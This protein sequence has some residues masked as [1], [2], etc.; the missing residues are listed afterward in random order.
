[1][2]MYWEGPKYADRHEAGLVL[3]GKLAEYQSKNPILLAI[4]NGGVAVGVPIARKLGC[5]L[6]LIVVRKLV[7]PDQPE[8]GFGSV[9]S[10][11]S[12]LL[13]KPLVR[14]F[15]LGDEM[16]AIQSERA[17]KTIGERL[18]MYGNRAQLPPLK[19]RTVILVD[20]GLASGFTM[21]AAIKVV[22]VHEPCMVIVAVPTS[23]MTAYR[24]LI[25]LVDR[26]VCPDVSGL[27]IF[28]V[29]DAY[30]QWR[31]LKDEEVIAM[32]E[33]AMPNFS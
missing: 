30:A 9:V 12:V 18:S 16:I 29:A 1:M 7:I 6:H 21:R 5:P 25:D 10:D 13:N 11:G 24:R 2:E 27:R 26:V 22:K 19:G 20:D 31:D 15:D 17:L 28:A 23:S 32:M 33:T 3:A 8:A 14:K 4:P